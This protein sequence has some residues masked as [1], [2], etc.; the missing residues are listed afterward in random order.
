MATVLRVGKGVKVAEG[1][2]TDPPEDRSVRVALIQ[3][4]IPLGLEAVAE[5]LQHD[6]EALVGPP[7]AR[8]QRPLGLHR[9]TRQAIDHLQ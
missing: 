1:R 5:L 4:L 6:V 7:Y 3:A 2:R 9:W 8:G